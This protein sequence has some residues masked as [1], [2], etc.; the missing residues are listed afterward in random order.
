MK[1]YRTKLS[2]LRKLVK[3]QKAR[4]DPLPTIPPPTHDDEES[5]DKLIPGVTTEDVRAEAE[6]LLDEAEQ[7]LQKAV[8]S[9]IEFK[10]LVRGFDQ[11][12][13]N[14]VDGYT[15]GHL[16]AFLEEESQ[17]GSIESLRNSLLG[18]DE[19]EE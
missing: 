7:Y 14:E 18:V 12:L 17:M 6:V 4:I 1:I 11:R 19:E 9:L 8:D 2:E 16:A 3:E 5:D 10:K 13:A 15:I